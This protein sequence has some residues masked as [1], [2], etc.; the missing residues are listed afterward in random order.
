MQIESFQDLGAAGALLA[1]MAQALFTED[2]ARKQIV[3]PAQAHEETR[4]QIE[5]SDEGVIVLDEACVIVGFDEAAARIFGCSGEDALGADVSLLLVAAEEGARPAA[6]RQAR[7]GS[8]T[9]EIRPDVLGRRRSGAT[10]PLDL[11]VGSVVIDGRPRFLLQ[12]RDRVERRRREAPVR[13]AEARYRALVEQIPAVTFM[14]ALDEGG[15]EM[16][17]SPQIEALLGFSQKEWL[18]DPVLWF[19]RLHVDDQELWNQEFARGSPRGPVPRRVPRHRPRRAY[20]L[21]PRRGAAR[22][23]RSRPAALPSGIAFDI[24]ELK[25]AERQIRDAQET[26]IRTER[27]AAVGRLA[28]SIGHDIRNPLAA[29]GNAYHYVSKRL[30]GTPLGS[31]AR[32]LQFPRRDGQGA[33]G[34]HAHRRRSARLRARAAAV[35]RRVPARAARGRRGLDRA[36][37]RAGADPERGAGHAAHPRSRQGSV[38]AGP[39]EPDPE[40]RRRPSRRGATGACW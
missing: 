10:I 17:V 13:R 31:D 26:K 29:I 15:N 11:R 18:D 21:D 6:I 30:A 38:P 25:R 37:A 27:L 24:T 32:V 20:R 1:E 7:G 28:A 16:Y 33:Q 2:P 40:R 36:G 4:S 35:P 39:G 12:V 34:L 14:A 8:P 5:A 23:R 19:K 9:L 3:M 22:P